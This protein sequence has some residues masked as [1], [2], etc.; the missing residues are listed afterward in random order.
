M[1]RI[2]IQLTKIGEKLNS[3][4]T[5]NSFSISLSLQVILTASLAYYG[6]KYLET[7]TTI[8]QSC[9]IG[10]I[11]VTEYSIGLRGEDTPSFLAIKQFEIFTFFLAKLVFF[12][13]NSSDS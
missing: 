4:A 5:N 2:A 8:F 1:N 6:T 10:E 11:M 12:P 3:I 7:G 9:D 13:L